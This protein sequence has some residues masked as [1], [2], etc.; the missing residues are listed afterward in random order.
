MSRNR[1]AIPLMMPPASLASCPAL[2]RK[3]LA[4]S[5][6]SLTLAVGEDALNLIKGGATQEIG[7]A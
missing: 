1:V 6:G 2:L 7:Q 4:M 3:A 5:L